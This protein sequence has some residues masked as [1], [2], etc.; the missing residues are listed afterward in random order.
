M[1][2]THIDRAA[3]LVVASYQPT[4][5][6]LAETSLLKQRGRVWVRLLFFCHLISEGDGTSTRKPCPYT[7]VDSCRP[8]V[9]LRGLEMLLAS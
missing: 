7:P 3:R 4:G 8:H 9:L 1:P 5:L 6:R 2:E